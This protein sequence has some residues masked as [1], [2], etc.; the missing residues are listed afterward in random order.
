MAKLN[1][2]VAQIKSTGLM[3][4][5]RYSVIIPD[6]DKGTLLALYC[7]QVQLPGLNYST[8]AN[9]SYGESREIPYTRMFDNLNM[10]FYVDN[11][12]RIK[13]FFDSWL[14]S[15]QNPFDRTFNYYN[16]YVKNI[17]IIVEDLE[18]KEKYSIMLKECYPKTIG[19]IQLDYASKDIMKLSV[20][21]A[22][23]YWE[24]ISLFNEN[25]LDY[26]GNEVFGIRPETLGAFNGIT[27]KALGLVENYGVTLL[28]N[29]LIGL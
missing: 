29:A 9:I 1:D 5:A 13:K 25:E 21:M 23:K 2:F 18:N 16:D 11:D 19:T 26:I 28:Q 27:S 3:R 15:V 8:S 24:P 12:M 6:T 17:Q 10:S 4:T 14:Y 20:T 7:D 22:Y